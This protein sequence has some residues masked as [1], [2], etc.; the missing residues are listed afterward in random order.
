MLSNHQI[1][2]LKFIYHSKTI[3]QVRKKYKLNNY[4]DINNLIEDSTLYFE[5]SDNVLNDDTAIFLTDFGYATVDNERN[6]SRKFWIP[7]II[8][9]IALIKSFSA[10]LAE[11]LTVLMQ[12]KK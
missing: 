4:I 11:L 8:S 5:Y 3:R 12:V 7:T 10:E 2:F 9:I 1:K 6:I